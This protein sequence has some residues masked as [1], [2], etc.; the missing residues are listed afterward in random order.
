MQQMTNS[1]I[2]IPLTKELQ[3]LFIE[4]YHGKTTNLI[5]DFLIYLNTKKEAYDINKA[6]T[7]VKEGNT[8]D[9]KRL[10]DEL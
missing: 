4:K 5:N 6:L 1:S 7:E 9:I 10:L 3:E 2:E 8:K